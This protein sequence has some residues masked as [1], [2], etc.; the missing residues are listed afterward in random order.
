[1]ACYICH[2]NADTDC[3]MINLSQF[4]IV[5]R[6]ERSMPQVKRL[7]KKMKQFPGECWRNKQYYCGTRQNVLNRYA[8]LVHQQSEDV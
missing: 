6:T 7:T 5:V 2:V 8:R 1:M 4:F 3:S